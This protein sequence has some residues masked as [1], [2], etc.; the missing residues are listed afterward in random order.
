MSAYEGSV[1]IHDVARKNS[2]VHTDYE[3][4][5]N[6]PFDNLVL[7]HSP[8]NLTSI[9]PILSLREEDRIERRKA[10]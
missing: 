8:D 3:D 2:I 5:A 9:R 7:T 10:I 1:I 6:A 4:I